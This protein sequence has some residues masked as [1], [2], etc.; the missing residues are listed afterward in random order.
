MTLLKISNLNNTDQYFYI[1]K[2]NA[3]KLEVAFN[4][5]EKGKDWS[6]LGDILYNFSID[7]KV[8]YDFKINQE[9]FHFLRNLANEKKIKKSTSNI[10]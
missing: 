7:K 1:D 10:N 6:E 3:L 2:D 5:T 8:E 4:L 9:Q